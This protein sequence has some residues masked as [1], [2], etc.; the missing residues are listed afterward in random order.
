MALGIFGVMVYVK[1]MSVFL[2]RS[3]SS[4]IITTN[5][6]LVAS[7]SGSIM[8]VCFILLFE[9]VSILFRRTS[10]FFLEFL[11]SALRENCNVVDQQGESKNSS[12]F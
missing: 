11:L 9:L 7:A 8:S 6:G 1:S 2:T 3:S 4:T 12:R 5:V 10:N